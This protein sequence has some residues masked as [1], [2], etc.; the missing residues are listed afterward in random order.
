MAKYIEDFRQEDSLRPIEINY[1]AGTDISGFKHT[2]TLKSSPDLPDS[3]AELQVSSIVGECLYD[4]NPVISN[5]SEIAFIDG[6]ITALDPLSSTYIADLAAL[7]ATKL[8]LISPVRAYILVDS[9]KT[10]IPAGR[11]FYDIQVIM[12]SFT[13]VFTLVPP[14][15]E[16]KKDLITV[17]PQITRLNQ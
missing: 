8:P 1:P 12:S 16:Y 10:N 4:L 13:E 17:V 2:L 11:Y 3:E 7:N 5:A 9:T 14:P 15:S 6:E